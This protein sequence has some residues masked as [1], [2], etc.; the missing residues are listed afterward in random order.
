[1]ADGTKLFLLFVCGAVLFAAGWW[2][3]HRIF[4]VTR[5]DP[6]ASPPASVDPT[7]LSWYGGRND[8][9]GGPD[10]GGST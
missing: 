4:G 8:H 1:M 9:H 3:F 2:V 10:S 6:T 7:F 5:H